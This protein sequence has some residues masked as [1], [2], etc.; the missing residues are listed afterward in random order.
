MHSLGTRSLGDHPRSALGL[1]Q[2]QVLLWPSQVAGAAPAGLE[3]VH[4]LC[5]KLVQ[6]GGFWVASTCL[7]FLLLLMHDV[8]M[9][10]F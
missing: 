6:H 9:S 1:S 7:H 3:L 5:V 4:A 10:C 8:C 2:M